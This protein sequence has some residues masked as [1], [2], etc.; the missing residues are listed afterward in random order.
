MRQHIMF[1]VLLAAAGCGGDSFDAITTGTPGD[2][3]GADVA[4]L[5]GSDGSPEAP[6]GDETGNADSGHEDALGTSDGFAGPDV[7][8]EDG[9]AEDGTVL[10]DDAQVQD[11]AAGDVVPDAEGPIWGPD[12][13]GPESCTV[14][15]DCSPDVCAPY[16]MT[17]ICQ[18][19]DPPVPNGGACRCTC[20]P[21]DADQ[22]EQCNA[23][24]LRGGYR[25]G[26]CDTGF[27]ERLC[28]CLLL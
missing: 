4:P 26:H 18:N 17:Q 22:V 11:D 9:S 16:G 2:D 5:P 24:C 7:A 19:S 1:A 12:G 10:A 14:A 28:S 3:A 13:P 8:H 25:G 23:Q 21:T 27:P 20:D 15:A 6:P